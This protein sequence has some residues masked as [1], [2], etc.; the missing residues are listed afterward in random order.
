MTTDYSYTVSGDFP[1]NID[2]GYICKEIEDNGTITTT[3][4]G[5]HLNGDDVGI[6]FLATLS[7]P[8]I[9]EL[10][11]LVAAHNG[12]TAPTDQPGAIYLFSEELAVGTDGGTVATANSWVTRDLN[13]SSATI[14]QRPKVRLAS[15]Q[16]TM[17]AGTYFIRAKATAFSVGDHTLRLRNITDSSTPGIGLTMNSGKVSKNKAADASNS[18]AEVEA[19]VTITATKVFE[20]QHTFSSTETS[21]GKGRASGLD[22]EK[23]CQVFVQEFIS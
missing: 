12:N 6:R 22:T 23:Y 19:I 20:V 1:N 2:I 9:T 11:S 3:L 18:I 14:L 21:T 7:A 8:E 13:T 15:N 16:L 4:D 10:N 17:D 5:C